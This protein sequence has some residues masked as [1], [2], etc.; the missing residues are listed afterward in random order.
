MPALP[1]TQ[2]SPIFLGVSRLLSFEP[3]LPAGVPVPGRWYDPAPAVLP[4]LGELAGAGVVGGGEPLRR[5]D[6]PDLLSRRGGSVRTGGALLRSPQVLRLLRGAGCRVRVPL[7]SARPE[8]ARWLV[9]DDG[10]A[11]LRGLRAAAAAGVPVEAEIVLTRPAMPTVVALTGLA[12]ELGADGVRFVLPPVSTL[13]SERVVALAARV[14]L[15]GPVGEAAGL[16]LRAGRGLAVEGAPRC[17]LPALVRPYTNAPG[18]QCPGCGDPSCSGVDAAYA[19]VFGVAEL[20]PRPDGSVPTTVLSLRGPASEQPHGEPSR[21]ARMRLLRALERRP[22]LLWVEGPSSLRHPAAI[23]LLREALR[24]APEVGVRGDLTPVLEWSDDELHRVRKLARAEAE[25][26]APTASE[27]DALVGVDGAFARSL[28]AVE[29]MRGKR[30]PAVV[31]GLVRSADDLPAWAAAW[32]EGHLPG[33]P[34]LRPAPGVDP[35]VLAGTSWPE[36]AA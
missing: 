1:R 9:G 14:G 5:P 36:E 7:F 19:E 16:V 25:L 2:R 24:A 6:A 26:L 30:I 27:H 8:A 13:P 10:R 34:R 3:T 22:E 12:L 32:A 21:A 18:G 4:A 29:R 11:A 28:E 17:A 33:T 23:A 20:L 31:V 15:L 35:A